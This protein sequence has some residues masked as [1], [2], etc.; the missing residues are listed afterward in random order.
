MVYNPI[1][2]EEPLWDFP[3]GCQAYWEVAAYLVSG[4]LGWNI[5]PRTWLRDGPLTEGML[6]L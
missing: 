2:G 5:V 6:Q 1:A 3:D 4:V